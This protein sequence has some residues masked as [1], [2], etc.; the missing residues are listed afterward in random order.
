MAQQD[1]KIDLQDTEFTMLSRQQSRT[2][3][4]ASA[5]E[6]TS[7]EG[8]DRNRP[9][10]AY[11]H[12][13]MPT[14]YGMKSV[15][16]KSQVPAIVGL[17]DEVSDTKVMYGDAS[18]RI[19]LTWDETG[20]TYALLPN[21]TT[22]IAI[23][24]PTP[25]YTGVGF[26]SDLITTAV[27]NGVGY[28][29][30][31]NLACYTYNEITNTL[32]E[33]TLTGLQITNTVGITAY[34]GYLIAFTRYAVA[35]SSTIDPTDFTPSAVTGAGGGKIDAIDGVIL[36]VVPNSLGI[37]IYSRN[38]AVAATYTGNVQYPFKFRE[39]EGSRGGSVL[40]RVSYEANSREQFTYD[41]AGLQ[42]V[43]SQRAVNILP[44]VSDFLAG[45]I[46][47][48]YNIATQS[49]DLLDLTGTSG[50]RKKIKYI[51]SRYLIISYGDSTVS[52]LQTHALIYDTILNKLGK[53]LLDHVNVLEY[54][55]PA[56]T[57]DQA[58][59]SIGFL[60]STGEIK[61]VDFDTGTSSDGVLILGKLQYTRTRMITLLSTEVE[62]IPTGVTFSL[63][64]R[65]S[66]DGK[67]VD[68]VTAGYLAHNVDGLR[69]Y[70]FHLTGKNHSL[71]LEGE[72]H[73]TSVQISFSIHGRR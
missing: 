35:W 68:S 27:V 70:N 39:I 50:I 15:G 13:V 25:D 49:Y 66:L 47:E 8:V 48:T 61:T 59:N 18:S 28:L 24:T 38:N 11:C 6:A 26:S 5:R 40:D 12:N 23:A 9:G 10:I 62:T 46:I 22:W 53:I 21:T 42:A 57:G 67:V 31:L 36:I 37:V 17:A 54:I 19:E 58:K 2:I 4:G 3:I 16:F 72:F 41:D 64:D 65:L 34:A 69:I 7:A 60:L 30:Y 55:S 29:C 71:A 63:D 43:D 45:K 14:K 1:Y 44:E 52:N 20:N 51:S 73:A 32:D 33:V 56:G